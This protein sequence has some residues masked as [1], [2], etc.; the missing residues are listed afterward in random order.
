MKAHPLFT[1][2]SGGT[3]GGTAYSGM[4]NWMLILDMD[5]IR[6]RY[7]TDSDLDYETKLE[8]NGLDGMKS[9]YIGECGIEIEFAE[10]CHLWKNVVAG[11]ADT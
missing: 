7:L 10:T 3:T 5:R 1:Q 4:S 9:G 8:E 6:Y 2:N 11:I